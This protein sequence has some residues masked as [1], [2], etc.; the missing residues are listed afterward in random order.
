MAQKSLS[1][2]WREMGKPVPFKQFAHYYNEQVQSF[3]KSASGEDSTSITPSVVPGASV[4]FSVSP[5]I[6]GVIIVASAIVLYSLLK[7]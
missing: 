7:K 5:V 4:P 1:K 2:L 6:T 3:Y